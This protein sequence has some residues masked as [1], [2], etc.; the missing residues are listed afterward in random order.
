MALKSVGLCPIV[1]TTLIRTKGPWSTRLGCGMWSD[2]TYF[3]ILRCLGRS[4][5]RVFMAALSYLAFAVIVVRKNDLVVMYNFFPEYILAA[6]YLRLISRPAFLDLEDG[7]RADQQGLRGIVNRICYPVI[8]T[9]CAHKTLTVSCGLAKAMGLTEFLP[10][11]GVSSRFKRAHSDRERFMNSEI[12]VLYGGAIM[13]ETGMYLFIDA[14]KILA[15]DVRR[16]QIHFHVTGLYPTASFAQLA[17]ELKDCGA[18]RMSLYPDLLT[19]DY[20]ALL[21]RMDVGLCLKLPSS[22]MG[23]TTFPSKVIEIASSG[24]LLCS[25]A[26]S[27]IPMIFDRSSAII[28]EEESANALARE[29]VNVTQDRSRYKRIAKIGQL[30][31]SENFSKENVGREIVAFLNG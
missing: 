24:M 17:N 9:L 4:R 21:G 20:Q 5:L 25:T 3:V 18:V 19:D 11:Y 15:L 1:V 10:V 28:L 7:P 2:S 29:L 27:D 26:V 23:R 6:A 13:Q 30:Q 16:P 8:A 22:E 12:N 31:I 14:V